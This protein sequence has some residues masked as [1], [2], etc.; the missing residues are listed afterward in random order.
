MEALL[1]LASS[2]MRAGV[3]IYDS[4]PGHKESALFYLMAVSPAGNNRVSYCG[5]SLV[6]CWYNG[7][8]LYNISPADGRPLSC[9]SVWDPA[10]QS[11]LDSVVSKLV[12]FVH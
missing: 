5:R 8:V 3:V 7:Q 6:T 4:K 10:T 9:I 12:S 2:Y 11:E 1:C